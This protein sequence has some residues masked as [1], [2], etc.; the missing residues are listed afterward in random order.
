M[1]VG[2]WALSEEIILVCY[3]LISC[4]KIGVGALN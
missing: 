1:G 2:Q 4:L 3:D